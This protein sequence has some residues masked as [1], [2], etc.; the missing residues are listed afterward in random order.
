MQVFQE[1]GGVGNLPLLTDVPTDNQP[2]V[3]IKS[4]PRPYAPRVFGIALDSLDVLRVGVAE[5]P[6]LI[7]LDFVG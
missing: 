4:R 1:I 7:A 3:N 2:G 5:R 6:Q